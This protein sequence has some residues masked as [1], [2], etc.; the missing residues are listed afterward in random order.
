MD[1]RIKLYIEKTGI[2]LAVYLL[3]KYLLPLVFPFFLAWLTVSLLASA[4]RHF[5]RKLLPFTA[6][7]VAMFFFF[8]AATLKLTGWLLLEPCKDLIPELQTQLQTWINEYAD[9]ADWIPS[10]LSLHLSTAVPPVL[11]CAFGIF[12]YFMAVILFA[13][14]WPDFQRL[15]THLPFARPLEHAG[16]RIAQSLKGWAHAQIRIMFVIVLECTVGYWLLHIPGAGL[17]AV[18]TGM[19]DALP[20]FGTGTIFVPWLILVFCQK[21]YTFFVW[22]LLLYGITWLTRELLE[23]KLLGDG[24]GLLPVCFLISVIVGLKLFGAAGL[25]TGPFSIL[26]VKELW[27]ELEMWDSLQTPSASRCGD[28]KR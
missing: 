19:V 6:S 18:L 25:F 5:H 7:V 21:D 2:L 22:L 17:W 12:L 1:H 9:L 23:P 13:H 3:L 27:T 4:S 16:K 14:D 10:S 8:T 20:V 15:L 11:S 28:E 26:F 24:L